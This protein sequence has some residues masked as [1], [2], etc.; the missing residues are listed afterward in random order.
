MLWGS[1]RPH[2]RR[3]FGLFELA[4]ERVSSGVWFRVLRAR[5]VMTTRKMT[6]LR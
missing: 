4:G 6:I 5:D 2:A 3:A 1:E